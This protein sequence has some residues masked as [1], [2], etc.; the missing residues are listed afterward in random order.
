MEFPVDLTA[1]QRPNSADQRQKLKST[2]SDAS[3]APRVFGKSQN[4][5]R[6]WS[7]AGHVPHL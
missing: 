5:Q 3:R 4:P 6:A 1:L 2:E 7:Q